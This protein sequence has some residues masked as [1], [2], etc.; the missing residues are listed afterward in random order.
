METIWTVLG[1]AGGIALGIFAGFKAGELIKERS[2][3]FY[4]ALNA[5]VFAVGVVVTTVGLILGWGWMNVGGVA[6]IAG[7]F[8]GLKYG[9]GRSVGLWRVHDALMNTDK[10]MR[11]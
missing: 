9:Y 4:W 7:G 1:G 10:D 2:S 8:T 6:F 5:A 11:D 3:W